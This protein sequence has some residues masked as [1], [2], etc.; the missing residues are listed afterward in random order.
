MMEEKIYR[1]N[2]NIQEALRFAEA[3]NAAL[4]TFNG[5]ALYVLI[6]GRD[7]LPPLIQPYLHW[8]AAILIVGIT[9]S[10]IAFLPNMNPVKK[11][12]TKVSLEEWNARKNFS[13]F[14]FGHIRH[15]GNEE[16]LAKVYSNYG[17]KLTEPI[18]KAE[19]DLA[20]QT[21]ILSR[22]TRHKYV[23]FSIAGHLTLI[24]LILPV[25]ILILYWTAILLR[26]WFGADLAV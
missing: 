20:T 24:A 5:A 21:I 11:Q 7:Y 16:F 4:I 3:K 9:L 26:R 10:I 12:I 6:E 15:Y 23:F 22:I 19:L 18:S 13:I 25:P 8:L 2:E 17:E 14:Y 1:I